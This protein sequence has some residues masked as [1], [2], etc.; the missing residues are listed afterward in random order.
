MI[1]VWILLYKAV[2]T[3]YRKISK[4]KQKWPNPVEEGGSLLVPGT[5]VY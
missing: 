1:F 4:V 5:C 2:D 3:V